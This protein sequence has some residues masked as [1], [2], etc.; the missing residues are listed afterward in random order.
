MYLRCTGIWARIAS[1]G[2]MQTYKKNMY[3]HQ[4]S[5]SGQVTVI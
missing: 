2:D 5:A 1:R 4:S 3:V